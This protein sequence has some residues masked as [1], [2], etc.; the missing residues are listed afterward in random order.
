MSHN[1]THKDPNRQ[2]C[3]CNTQDIKPSKLDLLIT[4]YKELIKELKE[5]RDKFIAAALNIQIEEP[6]PQEVEQMFDGEMWDEEYMWLPSMDI[7]ED[8][9][10][11]LN[12]DVDIF[13]YA[14]FMCD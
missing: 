6:T 11:P 13:G 12:I 3:G 9:Y 7:D 4:K 1:I 8:G 5:A 2:P 10:I 14:H